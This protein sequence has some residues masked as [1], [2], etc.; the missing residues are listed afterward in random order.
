[1]AQ[2]RC[3]PEA[4]RCALRLPAGVDSAVLVDDFDRM[5]DLLSD[6]WTRVADRLET[7]PHN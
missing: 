2:L 7:V 1:V 6:S 4:D 5:R 3:V